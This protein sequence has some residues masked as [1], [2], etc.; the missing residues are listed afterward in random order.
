[1][2]REALE[3]SVTCTRSRV[4]FHKSQVSTVPKSSSPA[5]AAMRAPGTLRRIHW[6]LVAQK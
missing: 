6:I 5:W 1:M 2:V 4:R 3:T